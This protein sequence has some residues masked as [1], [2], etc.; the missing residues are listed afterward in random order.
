[1]TRGRLSGLVS[2]SIYLSAGQGSLFFPEYASPEN[3]GGFAKN[4]DGDRYAHFFSDVNYGNFRFQGLYYS[5]RKID[6]TASFDTNFNDPGTRITDNEGFFD[7][8][9]RRSLN[10]RTDLVVRTYYDHYR[11]YGTYAY[12]G[13]NS[14][15][16]Y[17]NYDTSVA[18]GSGVEATIG[19]K[20]G[21][22]H[23]LTFSSN[24]EYS[25]R[26]NQATQNQGEPPILNDHRTP[27]LA[28]IFAEGE[29]TLTPKLVLDGGAR[30][31]Y[32][33]T[34][35]AAVSP[36]A[37]LIYSPDSR[38]TLKYIFG[39]AFRAPNS[40]G[41]ITPMACLRSR[42]SRSCKTRTFNPT[43]L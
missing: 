24:Y 42:L 6:P 18:D 16:R 2:G 9:Y 22:R 28:A 33:Q 13:T 30:L 35:G 39:R 32:F 10:S 8:E 14:P 7:V 11:Y 38:T 5:R 34:Y 41:A 4:I 15:D 29:F 1:M 40:Y 27:W 12:G 36:R 20:L 31:D 21:T 17:L 3:N 43:R 26:V 19:R 37:A 23:H 25:F